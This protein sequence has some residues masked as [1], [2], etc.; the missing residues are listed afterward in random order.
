MPSLYPTMNVPYLKGEAVHVG[1]AHPM[2]VGHALRLGLD[3]VHGGHR[4]QGEVASAGLQR[5]REGRTWLYSC[6]LDAA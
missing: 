5:S 4:A 1:V 2:D 6:Q 3:P